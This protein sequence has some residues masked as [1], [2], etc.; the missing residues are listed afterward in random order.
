MG[1]IY[2]VRCCAKITPFIPT[3]INFPE[4]ILAN[5][6]GFLSAGEGDT[7]FI[8]AVGASWVRSHPGPF[9]WEAM[10]KESQSNYDHVDLSI[11]DFSG[12]DKIV[13]K[14]QSQNIALVVTLWPFANWDQQRKENPADCKV[15]SQ[16]EFL[17]QNDKKD[18]GDYLPEYRCNPT[19]WDGYKQWVRAVVDRYDGDDLYDMDGL[20]IP[21]KYWEVLNE[22]DLNSGNVEIPEPPRLEFYREEPAAYADLL[23][24]TSAAIK[25]VDKEAK[26]LIS[27]A[28]GGDERFL[29][30]Y[31]KV[32]ENKEAISAFDI[33][34]VHCISN[35]SYDSFNVEPYQKMFE[36]LGIK[37]PIWVTEAEAIISKEADVNAT[38][39]KESTKKAIEL[40]AER[41]FYTR[42]DF[43]VRGDL[44]DQPA[45]A[46]TIT[47]GALISGQDPQKAYQEIIKAVIKE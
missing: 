30:F 1:Y 46:E 10:Q 41:I 16:D 32:F 8:K 38:Q 4:D 14:Y 5:K 21:I 27:G 29:N 12:S 25:E 23:I 7:D 47:S 18:R 24:R 20:K 19:D 3:K 15:S 17:A 36:D 13:E 26:V 22:P 34:N 2:W 45:Q 44:G 28:A 11:Y 42:Y 35:D 33:G 6:F 43:N 37:K 31:K 39:T 9:L 40:G